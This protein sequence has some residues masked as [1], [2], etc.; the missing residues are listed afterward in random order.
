MSYFAD[1]K[2]NK[3]KKKFGYRAFKEYSD[4]KLAVAHIFEKWN[5]KKWDQCCKFRDTGRDTG[6]NP[7]L[8]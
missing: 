2:S 4:D 6:Q 3:P 1:W 5:K 7:S 8:S